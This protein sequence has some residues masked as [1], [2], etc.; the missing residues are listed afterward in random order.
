VYINK[1]VRTCSESID[2]GAVWVGALVTL[3]VADAVSGSSATDCPDWPEWTW[4]KDKHD[5]FSS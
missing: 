1:S 5:W 4:S 2:G 3:T